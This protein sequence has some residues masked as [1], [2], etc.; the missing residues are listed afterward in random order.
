MNE[1][2]NLTALIFG[3]IGIIVAVVILFQ[4][5]RMIFGKQDNQQTDKEWGREN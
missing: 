5:I 1:D 3:T 4:K 2:L